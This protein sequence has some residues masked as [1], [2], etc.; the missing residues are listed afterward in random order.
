[1]EDSAK[2]RRTRQT[3]VRT[4]ADY[5]GTNDEIQGT[6]IILCLSIVA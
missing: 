4:A 3:G 2:H 6:I 5:A 1:L